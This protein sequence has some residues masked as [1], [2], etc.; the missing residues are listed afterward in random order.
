MRRSKL[1][2]GLVVVFAGGGTLLAYSGTAEPYV[3]TGQ[4]PGTMGHAIAGVVSLA[5]GGVLLSSSLDTRAW[6]RMG[7]SAGL[8]PEGGLNPLGTPDLTG[9]ASGRQ[10][11]V[12]TYTTGGGQNRSSTT[13][14][15][16][17]TDL[18]TPV[19][20][21][22]TFLPDPDDADSTIPGIESAQWTLHDGIA[23]IGDVPEGTAGTVLS[24]RVRSLLRDR[25]ASVSVGD[26]E[27][28]VRDA[29][30]DTLPEDGGGMAGSL[31]KGMLDV[32]RDGDDGL[33]R[34]V[35]VGDKGLLTDG[36]ELDR[37][38]ELV[39]AVADA[40]DRSTP[41]GQH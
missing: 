24:G 7:R 2:I 6:K 15:V 12:R 29:M 33:N 19:E 25:G 23:V 36:D 40:V 1:L 18:E 39:T 35:S 31:A 22:A 26:R 16:V 8:S 28:H 4:L 17:E 27:Q 14:T 5:L 34:S 13:H 9:S 20:W 10:V 38:V 30:L 11:R 21:G 41:G 3:T 37:R 32:G